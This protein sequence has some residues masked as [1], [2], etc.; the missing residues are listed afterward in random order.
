MH[1]YLSTYIPIH[2]HTDIHTYIYIHTYVHTYSHLNVTLTVGEGLTS[3]ACMLVV[4]EIMCL[5]AQAYGYCSAVQVWV[6]MCVGP[7]ICPLYVDVSLHLQQ[8]GVTLA[9]TYWIRMKVHSCISSHSALCD[10]APVQIYLLT[11]SDQIV[12]DIQF[13]WAPHD[14]HSRPEVFA[15]RGPRYGRVLDIFTTAFHQTVFAIGATRDPRPGQ[16]ARHFYNSISSNSLLD[17]RD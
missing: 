15:I 11:Y 13:C 5:R 6:C 8:H 16:S 17:F 10:P 2:I 14:S 9:L 7:L 12:M 1:A 3:L 4:I